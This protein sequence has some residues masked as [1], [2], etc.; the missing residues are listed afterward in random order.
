MKFLPRLRPYLVLVVSILMT[1]CGSTQPPATTATTDSPTATVL[2]KRPININTALL[3]E[4]DRLEGQQ[5]IPALSHRIQAARPFADPAELV[6]KKVLNQEQF[7]Q[8]KDQL[9]VQEIVLTGRARDVDY[10]VKLGLMR[11]HLLVAQELMARQQ[12]EQ[13]IPHFGH[14]VEEIYLDLEGQ[15]QE[16]G[17]PEFKSALLK[18]QNLVRFTPNSPEVA[19]ALRSAFS[20]VD[21]AIAVLPEA[22]RGS[23]ALL[24]PVINGLL[25]A[26]AA[27]YTAAVSG[28]KITA[29]IEYEDSRGFLLHAR[30][31]YARIAAG[32]AR[33]S[34]KNAKAIG[35]GLDE[36]ARAWP[37]IE[38]PLR[39]VLKVDEVLTSVRSVESASQ[40]AVPA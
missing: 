31:L 36:L 39:P 24:L 18:L 12:F 20:A 2:S 26:S 3:S 6:S 10:L 1:G 19:S 33:T 9:T 40:K 34:P 27:E 22:E 14:P 25:E 16:R 32:L 17:V 28:D 4:L 29:R 11:G 8:V 15:L 21:T 23:P 13:A 38:A 7:N 5:G 37:T 35:S 30:E